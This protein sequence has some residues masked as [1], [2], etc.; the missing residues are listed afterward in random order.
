MT[1]LFQT[2]PEKAN[3]EF[4]AHLVEHLQG[5]ITMQ[6]LRKRCPDVNPAIA[7][8]NLKFWGMA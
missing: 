1:D 6:D 4:L 3:G 2:R 5:R 8:D 7:R